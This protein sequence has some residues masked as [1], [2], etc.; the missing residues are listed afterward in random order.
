MSDLHFLV[1][2][3]KRSPQAALFN[4]DADTLDFSAHAL[5]KAL[6]RFVG[7]RRVYDK[8]LEVDDLEERDHLI[9]K[10]WPGA[11]TSQT[12]LKTTGLSPWFMK[13]E[14]ERYG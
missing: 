14:E 5:T 13:R 3:K 4:L 12:Q 10:A 7:C 8:C 2:E 9:K 1:V 6:H 11:G